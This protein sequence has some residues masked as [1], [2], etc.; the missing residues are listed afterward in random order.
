MQTLDQL[1]RRVLSK[2]A[3]RNRVVNLLTLTVGIRSVVT[4]QE[5]GLWESMNK[6]DSRQQEI[7]LTIVGLGLELGLKVEEEDLVCSQA[8]LVG[9]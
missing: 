6:R 3:G 1:S 4:T 2:Q 5:R 9:R 8:W 7:N